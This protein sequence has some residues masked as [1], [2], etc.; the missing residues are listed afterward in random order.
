VRGHS[1]EEI[2]GPELFAAGASLRRALEAGGRREGW[3]ASI[4]TPEGRPRLVSL[5]GAPR[6]ERSGA[7]CD[8]RVSYEEPGTE[9][10]T[11]DSS[12]ER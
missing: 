7:P 2:L 3:G 4:Q 5:S 11:G 10:G 1:A 9:A 12:F 8:P 6:I